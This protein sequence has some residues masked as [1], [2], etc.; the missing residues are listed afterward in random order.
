VIKPPDAYADL[1]GVVRTY[2][3]SRRA[4][5]FRAVYATVWFVAFICFAIFLRDPNYPVGGQVGAAVFVVLLALWPAII[6]SRWPF[7][8]TLGDDGVCEFRAPLRQKRV[9]AQQIKSIRGGDEEEFDFVIRY[10]GGGVHL[11]GEVFV[12]LLIELVRINPAI[13]VDLGER[14]LQRLLYDGRAHPGDPVLEGYVGSGDDWVR[15]FRESHSKNRRRQ[16]WI[17]RIYYSLLILFIWFWFSFMSWG[18]TFF[19]FTPHSRLSWLVQIAGA[20]SFGLL[21]AVVGF[22]GERRELSRLFRRSRRDGYSRG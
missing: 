22:H 18:L 15:Q 8:A 7:E 14:W 19:F 10:E 12:D 17:D 20:V 5:T 2:R 1:E 16:D 21:V 9:R 3:I 4:A 6:F 13:K 11:D